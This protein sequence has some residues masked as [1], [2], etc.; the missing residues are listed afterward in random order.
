M[1]HLLNFLYNKKIDDTTLGVLILDK[2]NCH[3]KCTTEFLA[4]VLFIVDGVKDELN[5]MILIINISAT[6]CP[7]NDMNRVFINGSDRRLINWIINGTVLYE[8]NEFITMLRKNVIEFPISE[9]KYKMTVEFSKLIRSYTDANKLFHGGHF[10]DAFNSI[11]HSLHYL[12]RLSVIE[13]GFYPE[14]TVWKQ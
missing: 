11:L 2:K 5:I 3:E 12:A 14:V 8:K 4:V 6:V 9:R 1:E 10:L 7:K 13:H